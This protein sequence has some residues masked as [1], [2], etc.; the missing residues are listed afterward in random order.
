MRKF[1]DG[2]NSFVFFS[3]KKKNWII[4]QGIL[5]I[6]VTI[7]LFEKNITSHNLIG[8]CKYRLL[9]I[10]YNLLELKTK[11]TNGWTKFDSKLV[12]SFRFPPILEK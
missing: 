12:W 2:D 10:K 6:I 5:I 1:L 4:L 8:G 11:C 3:K 7:F 9:L